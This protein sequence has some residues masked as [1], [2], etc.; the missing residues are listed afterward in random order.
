[1]PRRRRAFSCSISWAC[2]EVLH[3]WGE[4]GEGRA[5]PQQLVVAVAVGG[6]FHLPAKV[7]VDANGTVHLP[8]LA[9]PLSSFLSPEA[10]A[11]LIEYFR[12]LATPASQVFSAT[13]RPETIALQR[14]KFAEH[15]RPALEREKALYRVKSSA[16]TIAGVYADVITPEDGIAQ[17]NK[18]RVL[19]NL[20]GG[21][22]ATGARIMG[23]LESIPVASLGKIKVLVLDYRQGPENKF[24]AASDDVV[25]VYRELLK[26]YK[27]KSIGIY[28]CSA[29]GFL[30]AEA[31]ARIEKEKLPVPGAIGIFCASAGGWMDGDSGYLGTAL[32]GYEVTQPAKLRHPW[33]SDVEYF[34]DADFND[35]LV[36]P[37]RSAAWP[38]RRWCATTSASE[39]ARADAG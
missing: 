9:V 33:V 16:A 13:P 32:I 10:K 31:A 34:T 25:A 6:P 22:F 28:G 36:A 20:H 4:D 38:V 15:F 27:P 11:G 5:R 21:G 7:T 35:P 1:M 24:P 19:I 30:T 8:P 2:I 39:C 12:F 37:I 14:K 29:G 23:A 3:R 18:N 26:N 17:K